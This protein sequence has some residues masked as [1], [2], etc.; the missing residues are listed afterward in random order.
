[1]QPEA[2]SKPEAGSPRYTG[3]PVLQ[4][5]RD[6]FVN[7]PEKGRNIT[8]QSDEPCVMIFIMVLSAESAISRNGNFYGVKTARHYLYHATATTISISDILEEISPLKM[9]SFLN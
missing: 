4:R 1:M 8:V 3:S 2:G 7:N 5:F 9:I 6:P